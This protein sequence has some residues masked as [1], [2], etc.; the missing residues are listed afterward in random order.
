MIEVR[1]FFTIIAK[2]GVKFVKRLRC[3]SGFVGST[4]WLKLIHA[5][6][7]KTSRVRTTGK[8]LAV[9][10]APWLHHNPSRY[11]KEHKINACG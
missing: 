10:L 8:A 4:V 9:Q 5:F 3:F 7:A 1:N 2:G 6:F 11:R